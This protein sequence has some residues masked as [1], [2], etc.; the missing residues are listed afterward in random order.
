MATHL[1]LDPEL[2]G[3]TLPA[4]KL[5]VDTGARS[6]TSRRDQDAAVPQ[7]NALRETL[8]GNGLSCPPGW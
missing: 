3:R 7:S 1:A 4:M 8:E 5:L 6:L 2:Q